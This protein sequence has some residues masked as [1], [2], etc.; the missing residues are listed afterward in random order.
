MKKQQRKEDIWQQLDDD[1]AE[2]ICG[3][4]KRLQEEFGSELAALSKKPKEIV[5]VGSR[6]R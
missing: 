5:V 6:I 3:G 1:Q 4:L 2:I